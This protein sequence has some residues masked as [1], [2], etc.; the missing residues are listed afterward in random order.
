MSSRRSRSRQPSSTRI[1]DDKIVELVAKLQALLPEARTRGNDRVR[2]NY[3][4]V[5]YSPLILALFSYL[6][7]VL[8]RDLSIDLIGDP[9]VS[10]PAQTS[11]S[12][13]L[14]ETCSY[15]QS[16]HR[17]A[18]DLSERLSE[19]LATAEM[20]GAQEEIIRRLLMH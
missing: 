12:R 8:G 7:S 5:E 1:A 10:S 4:S 9:Y 2:H 17:E 6:T 19:L 18:D 14:Q 20:T 13:V 3:K 11:A 16:L 15:I